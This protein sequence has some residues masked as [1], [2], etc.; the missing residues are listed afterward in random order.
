M[1]LARSWKIAFLGKSTVPRG[2][3]EGPG[4]QASGRKKPKSQ[5][6]LSGRRQRREFIYQ[7]LFLS[8]LLW[9][10][11]GKFWCH[12]F[13]TLHSSFSWEFLPLSQMLTVC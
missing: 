7:V 13:M 2:V 11:K 12:P 3:R 9:P 10:Q 8:A 5:K 1:Q 6:D 4:L